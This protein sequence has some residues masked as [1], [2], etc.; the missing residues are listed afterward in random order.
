M[1]KLNE[2]IKIFCIILVSLLLFSPRLNL[3]D[4]NIVKKIE[5]ILFFH[6]GYILMKTVI[7]NKTSSIFFTIEYVSILH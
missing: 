4:P 6:F 2:I 7:S 5:Y 3:F 1:Y